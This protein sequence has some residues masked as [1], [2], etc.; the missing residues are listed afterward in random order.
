MPPNFGTFTQLPKSSTEEKSST[1]LGLVGPV[2]I[3]VPAPGADTG[4]AGAADGD[5]GHA[6]GG[7][8]ETGQPQPGQPLA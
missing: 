6:D 1:I 3:R 5:Q 8:S 4:L 7:Q 2:S